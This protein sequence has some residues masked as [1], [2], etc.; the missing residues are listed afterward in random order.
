MR[1]TVPARLRDLDGLRAFVEVAEA[2][3]FTRAAGRL[4]SSKAMT[5]R[6]VAALEAA[7]GT[8]LLARNT[9]GV[10]LI[11]AGQ[12]F[13]VGARRL[14]A[15]LDE[16]VDGVAGEAGEVRGLVRLAAPVGFGSGSLMSALA[17]IL[18][19]HPRLQLDVR[20][21]DR[22]VDLVRDGFDIAIR[23][24]ALD[25]SSLVGRRLAPMRRAVVCSPD[26]AR[27]RGVPA[28]PEEIESHGHEVLVYANR[29]QGDVWRFRAGE[30]G[31]WRSVRGR[32]RFRTDS[33]ILLREAAI[34][35][36][37]LAVLPAF[38]A[39]PALARG[40][41][42]EVLRE[43]ALPEGGIHALL[44]AGRRVTARVRLVVDLLAERFA[45][46]TW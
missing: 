14:L 37:G 22:R 26:Y 7:L 2:A 15:D 25:D 4:G 1:N 20:L 24:G 11:E 38:V 12:H 5:S 36:A 40:E 31:E 23:A 10:S 9:H 8:P 42:I 39:A 32:A 17:E 43:H 13:L 28:T 21:D 3:S 19:A 34:R 16:A 41:L 29:T 46:E 35:G 27:R 45:G 30:G 18:A 6:R 33:A 44:P